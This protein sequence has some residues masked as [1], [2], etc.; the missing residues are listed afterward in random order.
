MN[1]WYAS[2][3]RRAC[4]VIVA[5]TAVAGLCVG[6]GLWVG[7][8]PAGA[9]VSAISQTGSFQVQNWYSGLCLGIL[10]NNNQWGN[11]GDAVQWTCNGHPDQA[12]HFGADN[13]N[14]TSYHQ[15]INN[16]GSGQ[17]LG[18]R[19]ASTSAG[20]RVAAGPCN[21]GALDQYWYYYV[22]SEGRGT[23]VNYNSG[24]LLVINGDST[25]VGDAVIQYPP[26]GHDSQH[27]Y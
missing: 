7:A 25:S 23:F 6:A 8:A 2:L 16:V 11:Q 19:G 22:D 10:P 9:A 1:R 27:W 21:T 13:S 17:C 3:R 24:L 26:N 20:A 12:W 14:N 15:V 5:A 4:G 18:V